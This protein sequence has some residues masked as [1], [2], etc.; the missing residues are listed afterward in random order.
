MTEFSTWMGWDQKKL[1][2]LGLAASQFL[3]GQA[4]VQAINLTCGFLLIRF[5]AKE[6]YAYYT[7]AGS[8]L[9]MIALLSDC[10]PTTV[11]MARG[12][13][14][15]QDGIRLAQWFKA[16][17]K[18]RFWINS[19]ACLVLLPLLVILLKQEGAGWMVSCLLAITAGMIGG[20]QIASSSWSVV[21]R[22]HQQSRR[23]LMGDMLSAL[24]RLALI[25]GMVQMGM[26]AVVAFGASVLGAALQWVWLR[27]SGVRLMNPLAEVFVRKEDLEVYFQK[28]KHLLPGGVFYALQ[29][30][31]GILLA[32]FFAGTST[33]AEVG[34]LSR[35]GLIFGLYNTVLLMFA[36]PLV[37]RCQWMPEL[38]KRF[39]AVLLF[40]LAMGGLV[41]IPAVLVPEM[42]LW[43]LG[44]HY[45]H[46][47]TE[48]FWV[49]LLAVAANFNATWWQLNSARAWVDFVWMEI[50]FRLA[51]QAFLL[52]QMNLGS[53]SSI[54]LFGLCSELTPFLMNIW[55]SQRGFRGQ[56]S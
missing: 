48:L 33:V 41:L 12:G 38:K 21:H 46:L 31:I 51:W 13:E 9:G 30:Q 40:A 52:T 18:I 44:G 23:L 55:L 53:V 15:W 19:L 28:L 43:L 47:K 7:V 36:V 10:G 8:I 22:L 16:A 42:F 11:L 1:R 32:T 5:L 54:L 27:K 20:L 35:L 25:L 26:G 34:A 4:A 56:A 37:A 14:V 6:D 39:A 2:Q 49:V 50:P 3:T 29:G 45:A 17:V 24:V